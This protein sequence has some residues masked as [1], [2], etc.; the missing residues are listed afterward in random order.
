ML[1]LFH[2]PIT[3]T[4]D[5]SH[6]LFRRSVLTPV[7]SS[8]LF[9]L[10][11]PQDL[12]LTMAIVDFYQL[13]TLF[14]LRRE[15][16]GFPSIRS[17]PLMSA[18]SPPPSR[19]PSLPAIQPGLRTPERPRGVSSHTVPDI[20][21]LSRGASIRQKHEGDTDRVE[22]YVRADYDAYIREDLGSR[23][24][25]DFE[26][27]MKHV[28][29]VPDKWETDWG[30]AIEAV[31]ASSEFDKHHKEYCKRCKDQD[32]VEKALYEP[33]MSTANAV[34]KVLSQSNFED[35]PPDITHSYRVNDPKKLRGG[36]F[37]RS[38]LSPDVVALHD[39][40]KGKSLHW[41]N[42]LH[43]LEVKPHNNALC[44]GTTMPR[45]VVDGKRMKSS[46]RV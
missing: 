20:T 38:D 23:V 22:K 35:I 16:A 24:F 19:S 31:K 37:N 6:G 43:V 44:D 2:W 9:N 17:H 21:P 32:S 26:V 34:L 14:K 10:R 25:V 40:C 29:H 18:T 41:A 28:L 15:N 3:S 39:D 12:C 45:L 46:F 8:L 5:A 7:L 30:P 1:S 11:G 33:L 13:V 27:F 4:R 36:I 42:P